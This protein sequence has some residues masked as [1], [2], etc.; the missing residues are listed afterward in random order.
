MNLSTLKDTPPW[1]WPRNAG[2]ILAESL[3]NRG[4]AAS[5][6]IIAAELADYLGVM[7]DAMAELLLSIVRT[8]DEPEQLRASAAISLCA[9]KGQITSGGRTHSNS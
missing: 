8:A 5:D 3:R 1:D 9:P 4:N 6:R 2:E 7:D